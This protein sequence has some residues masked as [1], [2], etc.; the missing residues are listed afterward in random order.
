MNRESPAK[1]DRRLGRI[2]RIKTVCV[3]VGVQTSAL[4]GGNFFPIQKAW[5][6][7]AYEFFGS[8]V[9]II[10]VPVGTVVAH[11][12]TLDAGRCRA[13][14]HADLCANYYQAG[15]GP[16]IDPLRLSCSSRTWPCGC[17]I[18]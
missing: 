6:D 3:A 1:C 16:S 15:D 10:V 7:R 8:G 14:D 9:E 12:G 4:A 17:P 18:G 2:L 13:F 11:D 5:A